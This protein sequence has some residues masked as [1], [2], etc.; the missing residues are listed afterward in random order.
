MRGCSLASM[1]GFLGAAFH[2]WQLSLALRIGAFNIRTFGDS[3]LSNTTITDLIVSVSLC[4]D[5]SPS[6]GL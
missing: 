6:Q 5:L 2:L 4:L 1:L 3:K